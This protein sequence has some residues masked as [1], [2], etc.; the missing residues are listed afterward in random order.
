MRYSEIIEARRNPEQNPRQ[1]TGHDGAVTKL[2]EFSRDELKRIGISMTMIDKIGVNPRSI[3]NTPNGV[4]FYPADYYLELKGK[5]NAKALPFMDDAPHIQIF[6][7]PEPVLFLDTYTLDDYHRDITKL[8]KALDK[9]PGLVDKFK[10]R[11]IYNSKL[12][13]WA[14]NLVKKS[15]NNY[16]KD[17]S[18]GF[19]P[20]FEYLAERSVTDANNTSPGGTIWYITWQL[21]QELSDV[22]NSRAANIWNWVLR[23]KLGYN[24]VVDYE[25]GIIYPDEPTQGVVLQT[26]GIEL[27]K[28]IS[29]QTPIADLR[30]DLENMSWDKITDLF[31]KKRISIHDVR[32]NVLA[33]AR[34]PSG[35]SKLIWYLTDIDSNWKYGRNLLVKNFAENR[36][37]FDYTTSDFINYFRHH[38]QRWPELESVMAAGAQISLL[39]W[40]AEHILKVRWPAIEQKLISYLDSPTDPQSPRYASALDYVITHK[41]RLPQDAEILLALMAKR[42]GTMYGALSRADIA[43][44]NLV[45]GDNDPKTWHRRVISDAAKQEQT[46]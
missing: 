35:F 4:Y 7:F 43:Y 33:D 13:L 3:Y 45:L 12:S 34:F 20:Y 19:A 6:K 5:R 32:K 38:P 18:V 2:Q 9:V 42:Y 21:C 26:S 39:L 30:S 46:S 22:L 15:G 29:N 36:Y 10:R 27:I 44:A 40:Y 31:A 37:S 25:Q 16:V 14:N 11:F 1:E 41:V 8:T 24:T 28:S 23:E 17:D